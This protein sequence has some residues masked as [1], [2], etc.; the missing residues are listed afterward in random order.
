[1]KRIPL[2][3]TF[4]LALRQARLDVVTS[5]IFCSMLKS[6]ELQRVT[7]MYKR[8]KPKKSEKLEDHENVENK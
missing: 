2:S 7:R 5:E 1:M 3:I 8:K 6:R 4:F